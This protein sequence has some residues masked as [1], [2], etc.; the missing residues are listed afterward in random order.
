MGINRFKIASLQ[1]LMFRQI[2]LIFEELTK[3]KKILRDLFR[4]VC[5]LAPINWY[6]RDLSI[7]DPLFLQQILRKRR[8]RKQGVVHAC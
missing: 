3:R 1:K 4:L 2:Q 8:C 5:I 6:T 7:V